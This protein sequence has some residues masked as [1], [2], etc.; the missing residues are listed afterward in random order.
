MTFAAAQTIEFDFA[1]STATKDTDY[2]VSPATPTLRAG[3]RRTT[4]TVTATA[5]SS[6]EGDETVSL[7]A[8]HDG[9][10][11]GTV[12]LTIKDA[13]VTP[14]TAQFLDVP[15]THDGERAFEF[16][17]RFSEEFPLGF[18]R[19]RDDAFDVTGGAVRRAKRL[20]KDSNL[21]WSI[22]VCRRR[23]RT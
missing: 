19:L 20:V 7:A 15:A 1:G 5:D 13:A 8:A 2:A 14:L 21:R 10:A 23:M 12:S 9:K 11:I 4:A 18:K 3:A 17:L 16:E 6:T 22:R